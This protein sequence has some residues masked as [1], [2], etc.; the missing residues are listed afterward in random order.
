MAGDGTFELDLSDFDETGAPPPVLEE[1][2]SSDRQL[3]ELDRIT[4][5]FSEM[6]IE[7]ARELVFNHRISLEKED[8][9][10]WVY[11]VQGSQFYVVRLTLGEDFAFT[12]CTCPNGQNRTGH[13]KCYHA[14]AAR[15]LQAGLGAW[16]GQKPLEEDD[17]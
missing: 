8:G 10:V 4:A 1:A 3:A 11:G 7:K 6:S 14:A 13:A 17:R 12:E 16:W 15:V 9:Q 2:T 5:D